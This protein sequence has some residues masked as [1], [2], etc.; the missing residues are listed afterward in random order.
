MT[1][2][3][4]NARNVQLANTILGSFLTE[5]HQPSVK[6]VSLLFVSFKA[7]DFLFSNNTFS[8]L[9]C[10]L[11]FRNLQ[12]RLDSIKQHQVLP[13]AFHALLGHTRK[14]LEALVATIA[15][16]VFLIQNLKKQL[17]Q[18][19]RLV[20]NMNQRTWSAVVVILVAL[21]P[22]H[23]HVSHVFK[24]RFKTQKK[25]SHAKAFT[26][27]SF[28]EQSP[29]LNKQVVINRSGKSR[30]TAKQVSNF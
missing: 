3:K 14:R 21:G 17:V 8:L 29:T 6:S 23:L 26:T 11:L 12:A 13:F 9:I 16:K 25:V 18:A 30:P 2:V 15:Q 28:L 4:R 24:T 10:Q 22:V 27:A 19:V 7:P 20:K 1:K 5:I